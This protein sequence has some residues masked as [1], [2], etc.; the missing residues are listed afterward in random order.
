MKKAYYRLV[1]FYLSTFL[2]MIGVVLLITWYMFRT[3]G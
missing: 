2:M 1:F 3:M